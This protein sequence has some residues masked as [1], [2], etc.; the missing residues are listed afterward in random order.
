MSNDAGDSVNAS[1]RYCAVFGHPV[2]HSASPAMQNAG[3]AAL[4]L[5]WR[6]LAFD[7]HPDFL[8]QAID[9]TKRMGFIGVNLTVPHKLL[10][11]DMVDVLDDQAR[12]LGAVNTIVFET[13][14]RAGSWA[15]VGGVDVRAGQDVRSR[16]LNTDADALVQALK[17]E[18]GLESLRGAAVLLLGAGGAARAAALR[19]AQ[20]GLVALYLVNRTQSRADQLAVEVAK[21][22][23]GARTVVGYPSESVDLVI[24]ATSLG[25]KAEDAL[26]I[27]LQWLKARRPRFVFDMIYRPMETGLLRAARSAGCRAANGASMLLHQGTR[28]LELWTG[29]PAPV[30]VMRAALEKNLYG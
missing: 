13:R 24:N 22:Y 2:N 15:P 30:K 4:G 12:T 29:R 18:F 11:V 8:R 3:L 23:P 19:L 20:E 25:L 26:P 7:V 6:Y 10:A 1:T 14:D 9:G 16:G 21:S 28:A 27:D 5:N 17:E